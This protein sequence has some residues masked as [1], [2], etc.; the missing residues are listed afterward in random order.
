MELKRFG[1]KVHYFRKQLGLTQGELGQKL[2]VSQVTIAHYEKGARFPKGAKLT[3]LASS[4]NVSI[5]ELMGVTG[6]VSAEGEKSYTK[7]ELI[8]LLHSEPLERG[9]MYL[10]N[11]QTDFKYD[12]MDVFVKILI[13]L[14]SE[15]GD[16][17][18]EDKLYISQEHVISEKVKNLI[19]RL[20]R[21]EIEARQVIPDKTKKWMGLCA[22]G[23]QHE[24]VLFMVCQ[25][26]RLSGWDVQYLGRDVPLEDLKK[27]VRRYNPDLLVFS[28]TMEQNRKDL[29]EY[30]EKLYR[31][32]GRMRL[33]VGGRGWN[34]N[35]SSSL[36]GEAGYMESLDDYKSLIDDGEIKEK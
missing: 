13:P 16:M 6:T 2:G 10:R 34:S 17:W 28:I 11:W 25:F 24:L 9:W 14:L 1:K 23:E 32:N 12:S 33:L 27:M 7:E 21:E 22:P 30:L 31:K 15:V 20:A 35:L 19:D 18:G 36:K 26:M 8:R 5:D 29:Q 4:L 3:R